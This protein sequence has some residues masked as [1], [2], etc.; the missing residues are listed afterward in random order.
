MGTSYTSYIIDLFYMCFGVFEFPTEE[1]KLLTYYILHK[2]TYTPIYIKKIIVYY[3]TV[4]Y[5]KY[6]GVYMTID[7]ILEL[8]FSAC[9]I[10]LLLALMFLMNII[11]IYIALIYYFYRILTVKK[12]EA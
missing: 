4:W 8:I 6:R 11:L 3:S 7:T 2:T 1:K 10:L 12:Y 9:I 5:C